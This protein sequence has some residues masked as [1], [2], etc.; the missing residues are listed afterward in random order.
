M[1]MRDA[2]MRL[3]VEQRE[4]IILVGASGLSYEEAAEVIDCAAGTVK[5]RVSRAR[6][7]LTKLMDASNADRFGPDRQELAVVA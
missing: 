4:A 7:R 1:Q 5:S 3:P 2:L 6:E